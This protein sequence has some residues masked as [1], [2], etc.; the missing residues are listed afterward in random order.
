V[1]EG[2]GT[3]VDWLA[4]ARSISGPVVRLVDRREREQVFSW[5]E[6]V[7]QAEGVAGGVQAEGVEPGERV[8]VVFPTGIEF[9]AGFFGVVLAG[10]VPVPL[11]PP[12]RLGRLDEYLVRTAAMLAAAEV[13]LVL[14]GGGAN[15]ILGEAVAAARP[16]RGFRTLDG[17][18]RGRWTPVAVEPDAIAMVQFSSGTTASPK[19]VA[20]SHRAVT[21][22]ARLLN[23]LWPDGPELVHSGVSWLPLYHDMGLIGCLFPALERPADLTLLPPE[24]F[25]ADPAR[26]LR[27]ISRHRATVSPAP[28]FAYALAA[29]RIRDEELDGVD[30]SSWRVA[31]NGAETVTA[32]TL[33]RFTDRFSAWGF[34]PEAMT[35]VYGLSEAALAVTFSP[36][37]QRPRVIEV[38]GDRLATGEVRAVAGGRRLVSLGS[39]L[40]GFEVEIRDASGQPRPE[41]LVGRIWARGPSM[42][43][44][45]LGPDRARRPR[46]VDEW[47]DTGDRGFLLDGE[48]FHA[49]RVKDV[50]ILRGRN[51]DPEAIEAAAGAVAGVRPGAA[52]AFGYRPEGAGTDR[53][54]VLVEKRRSAGSDGLS[55]LAERCREAVLTAT[56]LAVETVEVLAP[57]ALPRT[58]SG[59][60][61]RGE[62]LRRWE[63]GELTPPGPSGPVTM[64]RAVAR[65]QAA[66]ARSWFARERDHS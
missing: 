40:P 49:G 27:A 65:S 42:M 48:L 25:V 58:S 64:L 59:K 66:L 45:Y 30:L 24:T 36:L 34:R 12:V 9:L 1:G 54:V 23:A 3:L 47:L 56:G 46:R 35:P 60:K 57:G 19:A 32:E 63:R 61:R 18:G 33:E 10:A 29:D 52:V 17:L 6:V 14:A 50:I 20:L 39:A 28:N 11:Y 37:G 51:H 4:R 26:W 44:G 7:A 43:S 38:D 22:Q 55:E 8:A 5:A 2:G 41:G 21:T 53:L 31:I 62:A 15:R 13:I 16:R